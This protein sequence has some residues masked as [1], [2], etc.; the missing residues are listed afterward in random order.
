M[1]A[2]QVT[3]YNTAAY[4]TTSLVFYAD[5]NTS[6]NNRNLTFVGTPTYYNSNGP[7]V[8]IYAKSS[9]NFTNNFYANGL[10]IEILF[11]FNNNSDGFTSVFTLANTSSGYT[12]TYRAT[13]IL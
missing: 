1:W 11:N 12:S 6:G 9:A 13:I 5:V 8:S 3:A 7:S 10:T 4:V 2:E